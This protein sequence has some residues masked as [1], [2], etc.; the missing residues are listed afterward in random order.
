MKKNSIN[1]RDKKKENFTK[2]SRNECLSL[3]YLFGTNRELLQI[4]I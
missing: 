3:K 4:V 1:F 2:N